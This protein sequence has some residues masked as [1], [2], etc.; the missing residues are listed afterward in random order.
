MAKKS[1]G[2]CGLLA[3]CVLVIL[4]IGKCGAGGENAVSGDN[5]SRSA[6]WSTNGGSGTTQYVSASSL[7]CRSKA[8]RKARVLAKLSFADQV[9]VEREEQSWSLVKAGNSPCWVQSSHLSDT[10]PVR[11]Y[12]PVRE[13]PSRSLKSKSTRQC[14]G[15][16]TCGEMDSCAE[17][18]FYLDTCGVGRLDGDGDGVP[19]ERIC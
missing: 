4:V 8:G 3:L 19:C 11:Q 15:K 17:A 5:A 9:T 13:T 14:G 18:N 1:E 16:R 10:Y 7:N 2:G 6:D 12:Q